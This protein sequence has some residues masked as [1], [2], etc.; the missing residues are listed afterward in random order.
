MSH[1]FKLSQITAEVGRPL[2][3][4]LPKE[5]I[6]ILHGKTIFSSPDGWT[7]LRPLDSSCKN[8]LLWLLTQR[9]PSEFFTSK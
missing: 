1:N 5:L 7:M 8:G 9:I 3:P 2:I 6:G 4:I